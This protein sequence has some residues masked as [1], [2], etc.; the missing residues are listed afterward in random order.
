MEI[1]GENIMLVGSILLIAGVL[2]GKTSYRTGLPLLLVFLLVGMAFGCDGLGIR[3]GNMHQAQ[4]IGNAS[5]PHKRS[6]TKFLD[7]LTWLAQIVVFIMLGLLVNPH[8]MLSVAAV[9]FLI[10]LFM[11]FVG[12]PVSVWLS[13]LPFRRIAPRTKVFVS[14]VGLRGAVPIIFATYPVVAQVPGA[15]LIFN[16]VFFVTL[17]SL[18]VQGTTVISAARRLRLI[19]TSV[20][21]EPDFGVELADEHPTSLRTLVLTDEHLSAGNTLSSLTLPE[22]GLVIM[23]KRDGRYIVP[24]GKRRLLAGDTLLIIKESHTQ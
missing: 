20:R 10:G 23:I 13:L 17:L 7:G 21:E 11:I 18:L 6:I 19:D 16:I 24:N 1:S 12:R 9:S 3:F 22:K 5:L 8:E 2:I 15:S 14:W 4:M